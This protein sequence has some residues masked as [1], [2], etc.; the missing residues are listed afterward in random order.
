MVQNIRKGVSHKSP[1]TFYACWCSVEEK[2]IY[3][4]HIYER[5]FIRLTYTCGLDS[6]MMA[7]SHQIS[8]ESSGFYVHDLR[9]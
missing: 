8:Q 1:N 7:V 3:D 5:E 6:P 9:A 2:N 4:G